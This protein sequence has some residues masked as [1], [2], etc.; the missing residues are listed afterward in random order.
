MN[1]QGYAR[2]RLDRRRF[3]GSS[4]VPAAL[5][6][7]PNG[8]ARRPAQAAESPP[9]EGAPGPEIID[10]NVD[11]FRWP[12]RGLKYD[13]TE[14]L[15]RNLR[16]HRI[17]QAWADS[18]EA[19]LHKQLDGANRRLAD[20]CPERGSGLLIPID[21]VNPVWPDWEEDLRRCHSRQA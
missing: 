2:Q 7:P 10:S 21:T 17:V 1:D 11:L 19:V 18:F 6:I 20:E 16:R 14:T 3:V 4:L 8:R 13:R 15:V 5:A 9:E 12:F